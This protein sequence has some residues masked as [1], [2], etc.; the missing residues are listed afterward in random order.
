MPYFIDGET[1]LTE[2]CAIMKFIA[3]KYGPQLLGST[4]SQIGQVEMIAT[5]V[6]DLKGA[7]TMPCYT[8]GDRV[9]ITMNILEKVKPIVNF[10]GRKKFL[11]G[12][13]VTYV[14]F[15]MFELCDFMNWIS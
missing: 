15:I 9:G 12:E 2:P 6:S 14:D 4:P 13:N 1:R 11:C 7:T 3:N 10:L 8:Q 5:V